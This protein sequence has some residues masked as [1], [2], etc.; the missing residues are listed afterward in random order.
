L[1]LHTHT[2]HALADHLLENRCQKKACQNEIQNESHNFRYD[3]FYASDTFLTSLALVIKIFIHHTL[4][5]ATEKETRSTNSA[6]FSFTYLT[7][8]TYFR[9]AHGSKWL[10]QCTIA[11]KVKITGTK[12]DSQVCTISTRLQYIRK[13]VDR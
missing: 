7:D 13:K 5:D 6:K 11:K 12:C 3:I 1:Q 2:T 8:T 10:K 4:A 9:N